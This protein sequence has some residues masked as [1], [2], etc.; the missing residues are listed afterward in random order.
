MIIYSVFMF[1]VAAVFVVFGILIFNGHTNLINCYH[2]ERVKDKP[3]Y[4][5]KFAH[6]LYLFAAALTCSGI[7]GLFGETDSIALSSVA[8][9]IV[10]I[11]IGFVRLFSV[12]K[13]FGGGIF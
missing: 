6:S 10:G 3:L 8:I 7:V 12:Q 9:L 11:I 5:R 2:E 1:V 4:C 13:K